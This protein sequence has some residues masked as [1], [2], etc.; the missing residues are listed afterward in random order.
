MKVSGVVAVVLCT[1]LLAGARAA[2]ARSLEVA[3]SAGATTATV[4][5]QAPDDARIVVRYGR[6]GEFGLWAKPAPV[7][8]SAEAVLTDLEPGATYSYEV[9]AVGSSRP[10]ERTGSFTTQALGFVRASVKDGTLYV[11][12]RPVFPR[13]VFRQCASGIADNLAVG[14]NLFMGACDHREAVMVRAVGGRAYVVPNVSSR[15]EGRG[16]IGWHLRDEADLNGGLQVL[17]LLPGKVR[18]RRVAFLTLSSHFWPA[19]ARGPLPLEAYPAM[20]ARAGVVGFTLYPL[21]FWCRRAF[22]AVLYAQRHLVGLA[23]GKP[24][25]QWIEAA[26][27]G[28]SPCYR[29]SRFTPTPAT[30]RAETWLAIVGGAK[31]IGYFPADWAPDVKAEIRSLNEQISALAPILLSD[32]IPPFSASRTGPIK[33]TARTYNGAT[34]VFAVNATGRRHNAGF[35]I[36][37]LTTLSLQVL[38]E[39]RSVPVKATGAVSDSFE[40]FAVHVYVAAP[41]STAGA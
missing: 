6:S 15:A 40:P 24:T 18:D 39:G 31:G 23:A 36:S 11:D 9:S 5:W 7:A 41:P 25:F 34:Y 20:V 13:M 28:D 26:A 3:V 38:G 10:L 37:G 16:V 14:I 12:S 2:A 27:M 1:S 8:G 17:P 29:N 21:S 32:R 33:V 19:A 22:G 30:V 4:R 35:T